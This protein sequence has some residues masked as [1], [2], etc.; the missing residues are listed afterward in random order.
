MTTLII[1]ACNH[2]QAANEIK[3]GTI[4]GPE[5]Q[6]METAKDVALKKYNLDVD[7]VEFSDYNMPNTDVK[8]TVVSMRICFSINH[9]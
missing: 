8:L 1:S 9:I 5:T 2:Q 6:L 3:V 4:S 7:I